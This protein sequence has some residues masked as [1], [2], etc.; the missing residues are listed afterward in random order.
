M[1][2]DQDQRL[3]NQPKEVTTFSKDGSMVYLPSTKDQ[4]KWRFE[5][6]VSNTL[7]TLQDVGNAIQIDECDSS[8]M[9]MK[10]RVFL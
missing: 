9:D 5:D 4:G 10:S 8:F 2:A 1:F 6:S 7:S 3:W